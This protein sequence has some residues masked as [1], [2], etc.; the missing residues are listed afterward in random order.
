MKEM[1]NRVPEVTIWFW[2]I[3]VLSTT[4]G[5]TAADFLSIT[6]GLGLTITTYIMAGLLIISLFNQF[7]L[8]RYV[9]SSYWTVVVLISIMG[10]LI[11]D[12]LVDNYGMSLK[13]ASMMFTIALVSIFVIWYAAEKTLSV[14]TIFTLKRETFYWLAILFTFSL[15][16]AASDLAAESL[17][18][19]FF[20]SLLA[21]A[22]LIALI[23]TAYYGLN[24]NSILAF[25]L[26][27]IL[28]RP[29]GASAGD[30]L[31]QPI[32]DNGLG[33]GTVGTSA[34]FLTVIS[35]LVIYLGFQQ[36]KQ[37]HPVESKEQ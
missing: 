24:M 10:T 4:V 21:F 12:L 36:K 23:A 8:K 9:P 33:F 13:F 32:A 35:S 19:G 7:R 15:G 26:A 28:T 22:G 5:E 31:S 18:L 1:L 2:L 6:L 11:T 16:T 37:L 34:I 20:Y 25:W 29:L 17:G 14:H 27:Y 30:L 3:K